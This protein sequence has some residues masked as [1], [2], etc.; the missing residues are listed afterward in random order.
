MEKNDGRAKE[1]IL[2]EIYSKPTCPYC[3]N[4]KALLDFK[5]VFYK[6]YDLTK[7]PALSKEA[8]ERSGGQRTVPQIFIKGKHIGGYSEL[9]ALDE[10]GSLDGLLVE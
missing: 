4:A 5:R 3:V 1:K 10:S 7:D 2:V 6:E 9:K 8:I